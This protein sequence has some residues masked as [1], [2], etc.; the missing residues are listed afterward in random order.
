MCPGVQRGHAN[1]VLKRNRASASREGT[2]GKAGGGE[3]KQVRERVTV[4]DPA[5]GCRQHS[6]NTA[7]PARPTHRAQ[8]TVLIPTTPTHTHTYERT[9][10]TV[11]DCEA[12]PPLGTAIT[13]REDRRI[14]SRID[15]TRRILSNLNQR[16]NGPQK[17]ENKFAEKHITP[18]SISA[19]YSIVVL[20]SN[21][22]IYA[23]RDICVEGRRW[24]R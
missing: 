12:S 5:A 15:Y 14:L 4:G 9:T 10:R 17:G 3:Q 6:Y 7:R 1:I 24:V 20:E 11:S 23:T 8:Y 21:N 19:R 2:R 22:R 13:S 16:L 18:F